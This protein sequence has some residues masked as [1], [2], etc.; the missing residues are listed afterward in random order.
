MPSQPMA[1]PTVRTTHQALPSQKRMVVA[2]EVMV[3]V[4]R[5]MNNRL[6]MARQMM[7]TLN[8]HHHHRNMVAIPKVAATLN[9]PLRAAGT[10]SKVVTPNLLEATHS[11]H[12]HRAVFTAASRRLVAI[13]LPS[14]VVGSSSGAEK[15]VLNDQPP[16][17]HQPTYHTNK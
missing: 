4:T 7:G 3:V 6:C 1:P 15:C 5:I 2:V 12:H 10:P 16:W 8:R 13:P 11:P 17:I 14:R 9:L